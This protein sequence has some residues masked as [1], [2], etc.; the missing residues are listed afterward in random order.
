MQQLPMILK[1]YPKV[2]VLFIPSAK[3]PQLI[4]RQTSLLVLNSI[5]FPFQSANFGAH[6]R[7]SYLSSIKQC[8]A[9]ITA[10]HKLT[11]GWIGIE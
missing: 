9:R 7:N 3:L 1:K 8:L 10:S 11:A 6:Q 4:A 5:S 2:S